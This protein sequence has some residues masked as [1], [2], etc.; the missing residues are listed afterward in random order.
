MRNITTIVRA[1]LLVTTCIALPV[2]PARSA[3]AIDK[4][5]MG[6]WEF[7][8]EGKVIGADSSRKGYDAEM[9]AGTAKRVPGLF[10]DAVHF[11]GQHRMQIDGMPDFGGVK[12]ISFSAWVLPS[13]FQKYNEIFR[14]ED[15]NRRVL[16]SFQENATILSFGLNVGGYVE[17][18]AALASGQVLDGRWHHCAATFDGKVMRVFLDGREIGSLLRPGVIRAGGSA[19]GC[20]GSSNGRESFQGAMDNLRIYGEALTPAEVARL[21]EDGQEPARRYHEKRVQQILA[22]REKLR[23]LSITGETFAEMLSNTQRAIGERGITLDESTAG[24]LLE[25][26]KLKFPGDCRDYARFTGVNVAHYLSG[27][28]E[29]LNATAMR[30]MLGQLTEYMPLTDHQWARQSGEDL[31]RW[32]EIEFIQKKCAKLEEQGA[33]KRF[34]PEWIE[35]VLQ[36]GRQDLVHDRPRLQEPVAPYV[37][38]STPATRSLT[39]DEAQRVIEN[40]WMFQAGNLTGERIRSEIGWTRE[41]ARRIKINFDRELAELD[42]LD[43]KAARIQDFD[44][45]LYL[46][47]RRIKRRIMF[48]NPVVDFDKVVF[49]DM[50]YPGGSESHHETRH[51][52]GYMAVPG[53]RL[54]ALE[55]LSPDGALVQIM[56]KSPLHG[57]F[58]RPDVSYDGRKILF[59]FK[60][61]NEKSFHIY[62]INADGSDLRQLTSGPY[63]DLDPIYLPDGKHILFSSTRG[64]TYVRCMPPTNAFVL[65][66]CDLDGENIYLVSRN[67]E[68]DYLPSVMDDGRIVYTRWEYTDK[69]L[70]RAQGLWTVNPDGT[71]VN[72]FWGNQSVW[73]DLLKDAR[74]IPGTGRV[75][76]TGSAHHDWF[77]GSLGIIDPNKGSN[78]PKGLTKVTADLAWPE[79]GNGPSDPT[80]SPS[81][82]RSGNFSAYYSPYPLGEKDFLVSANRNGKFRLYL[83]DVDGNRELVYEGEHH[84]FHAIPLRKRSVPMVRPDLVDWPESNERSKPKGGIFYSSNVY[85]N[86]TGKLEGRAKFL[87]VLSID[88]KTYTYWHKR[89]YLST[90]PVVSGVQSE[91]VKRVLGT[92]PVERDGSVAFHVPAGIP[93]HFQLL[94]AEHRALQ[95]MRS[96][97]GV[98]PGERRGCV[99][100]HESH[101]TAP[102]NAAPAL[103][104]SRQPSRITAPSWGEDTVSYPRYVR[105]VLDQYCSSCHEGEGEGRAVFDTTP[106]PGRLG[107]DETYWLLTGRPAWGKAYK[108]PVDPPPGFGIAD[109]IMVEGYHQRDPVAYRTPEP[110]TRLSYKSRF[111]DLVSSGDHH[112]V[113]VDPVS[114][115]RLILWVDTMCPYRGDEEVREIDDPVFQ[116]IDWLSV[117][118]RIKTAPRITRPGPLD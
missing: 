68:P 34:A 4:P 73:P 23:K 51:R 3:V 12:K 13:S 112:G 65:T 95:T 25:I 42:A 6:Y 98:M 104:F 1:S 109:M 79:S 113:K 10:G 5:L 115:R 20:I 31:A 15:G 32:K 39:G 114:R 116:G 103:A 78:F 88:H 22:N 74:S 58:W 35:L 14:K 63:D 110:M 36:T 27:G 45:E 18:D 33:G 21:H 30:K 91:G 117:R 80:E 101:S 93:L 96:F 17:C 82:H 59:C 16:F 40:D 67:N 60:P 87:R 44:R 111:I 7:E 48:R 106:R 47:V 84:I 62:E 76:F 38:P 57:S 28:D 102:A 66:R 85:E 11:S 92:V 9:A 49:V 97:T 24:E 107:F 50:P 81:Y 83:M 43:R 100:C 19:P 46:Q 72:T 41:L 69:P 56:P 54:L 61:H 77:S 29:N 71:Q 8:G 108:K 26:L 94:D 37:E 53:A 99:G 2:G 90:G 55:G 64:H 86:T 118:P 105:P 89:P 70:W 52:L 75:M